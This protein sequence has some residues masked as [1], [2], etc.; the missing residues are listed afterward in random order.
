MILAHCG[1]EGRGVGDLTQK[2]KIKI[3]CFLKNFGKL[4]AQIFPV[5]FQLGSKESFNL[6]NE[7]IRSLTD[8]RQL[9]WTSPL[10]NTWN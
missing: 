5:Y 8:V 1:G 3:I 2:N 10:G 6:D 7:I 4:T 9:V